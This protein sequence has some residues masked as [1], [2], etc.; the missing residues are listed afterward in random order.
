MEKSI[1]LPTNSSTMAQAA[2][3][4]HSISTS[5]S[6]SSSTSAGPSRPRPVVFPPIDSRTRGAP[7]M[8]DEV[9][10]TAAAAAATA[11]STSTTSGSRSGSVTSQP[12]TTRRGRQA[13]Q[14][15]FQTQSVSTDAEL[16]SPV[17]DADTS[18]FRRAATW[19][20]ARQPSSN[21]SNGNNNRNSDVFSVVSDLVPD[22]VVN[23]L[24]GDTPETVVERR[25]TTRRDGNGSGQRGKRGVRVVTSNQVRKQRSRIAVL[26]GFDSIDEGGGPGD[27]FSGV[28]GST[29]RGGGGKGEDGAGGGS[30]AKRGWR[31]WT[32]GWR[33]GVAL[34]ALSYLA[35]FIAGL[36]CFVVALVGSGQPQPLSDPVAVFRGPCNDAAAFDTGLH[37][38][39]N[40]L[41]AIMLAGA[42][43]VAQVLVSPTRAEVAAAHDRKQWLDIGVPSVRNLVRIAPRR[44]V[45]AVLI[46]AVAVVTQVM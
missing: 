24:R 19:G 29:A 44:A 23:Y 18:F 26:E 27:R 8:A 30:A 1:P 13:M 37:A 25:M 6:S 31:R 43:Y 4:S 14:W 36:A 3:P 16:W 15:P 33:S 22:Y 12:R 32:I 40:V 41:V 9:G 28:S 21:G 5:T 42:S 35:I 20:P 11:R 34:S 2:Q 10:S 38:L 39:I 7:I 17:A 46:V 45:L